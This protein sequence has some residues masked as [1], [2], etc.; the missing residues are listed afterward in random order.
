MPFTPAQQ[1][2]AIT[3]CFAGAK[4][5]LAAYLALSPLDGLHKLYT[6]VGGAPRMTRL[7][8]SFFPDQLKSL[9]LDLTS[10]EL[11]HLGGMTIATLQS[12]TQMTPQWVKALLRTI[13]S[14]V[15]TVF[16]NLPVGGAAGIVGLVLNNNGALD[17]TSTQNVL[18]NT[19]LTELNA[20]GAATRNLIF[21]ASGNCVGEIN[22]ANHGG[23]AV[24]G[25]A[26]VYPI[27]C[28]PLTGHHVMGTPHIDM[29]D[30]PAVWRQLPVAVAPVT[31]LG[32]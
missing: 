5:P 26:H 10:M 22:F 24:S 15:P 13:T 20:V 31:V 14:P 11:T 12:F 16:V 6:A 18:A 9:R 1:L 7:A 21:N 17:Q 3:P 19:L 28:M 25:H 30:Y 8:A 23:T 2:A 27:L 32:L 29:A 4:K